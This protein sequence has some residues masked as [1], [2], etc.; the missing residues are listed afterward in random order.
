MRREARVPEFVSGILGVVILAIAL[1]GVLPRLWM[2]YW[3]MTRAWRRPEVE[4][5]SLDDLPP[6]LRE[7]LALAERPFLMH[8]CTRTAYLHLATAWGTDAWMVQYEQADSPW[9]GT[10]FLGR[11]F[12]PAAPF[13]VQ[14]GTRFIDGG[15]LVTVDGASH[16]VFGLPRRTVLV[17]PNVGDAARQL[18]THLD[19]LRLELDAGRQVAMDAKDGGHASLR[20]DCAEGFEEMLVEGLVV[21]RG[22][23]FRMPFAPAIRLAGRMVTGVQ[24]ATALA[25]ARAAGGMPALPPPIALEVVAYRDLA[26]APEGVGARLATKVALFGGSLALLYWSLPSGDALGVAKAAELIAGAVVLHELGHLAAMK[27]FGY[28][29]TGVLFVPFLGGAALGRPAPDEHAHQR[30]AVL[31]AGPLPGLLLGLGLA[32]AF[33]PA[34][35]GPAWA[36]D[37][38]CVLIVLNYLNLLP[39]SPLDGGQIVRAAVGARWPGVL[40]G[41]A[42]F[43]ALLVGALCLLAG[44]AMLPFALLLGL[45]LRHEFLVGVASRRLN[46]ALASAGAGAATA[47]ERL[48]YLLAGMRSAPFATMPFQKRFGYA[49]SVMRDAAWRTLTPKC[50]AAFALYAASL[51]LPVAAFPQI[52]SHHQAQVRAARTHLAAALQSERTAADLANDLEVAAAAAGKGYV[53]P[54]ALGLDV[55]MRVSL[56]DAQEELAFMEAVYEAAGTIAA[57]YHGRKLFAWDGES[58]RDALG[59]GVRSDILELHVLAAPAGCLA[60]LSAWHPIA[61]QMDQGEAAARRL[62]EWAAAPRDVAASAFV[63]RWAPASLH[64]AIAAKGPAVTERC[65]RDL[66]IRIHEVAGRFT[67]SGAANPACEVVVLCNPNEPLLPGVVDWTPGRQASDDA[68]AASSDRHR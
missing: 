53:A 26:E 30:I 40:F 54:L 10:L 19:A 63:P 57:R 11:P 37:F 59:P 29:A 36:F 17:D 56:R 48:P 3:L 62:R 42:A 65:Q 31:L 15:A 51:V 45:M 68:A 2:T 16:A 61:M 6:P 39:L 7:A 46:A 41:L 60:G 44:W 50:A 43:H 1:I 66:L 4:P 34:A 35:G 28:R 27:Y 47:A 24:K 55:A 21:P 38:A 64:L 25:K 32:W 12:D 58:E 9:S 67:Q 14:F 52:A 49:R 23:G 13:Q 18:G 8:G 33:P 5:A 22:A 20:R